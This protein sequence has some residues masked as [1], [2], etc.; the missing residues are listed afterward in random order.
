MIDL[1][2][3]IY[4]IITFGTHGQHGLDDIVFFIICLG[5]WWILWKILKKYV[6]R[7]ER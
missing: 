6:L 2:E 1:I 3:L 7:W 5:I 4:E